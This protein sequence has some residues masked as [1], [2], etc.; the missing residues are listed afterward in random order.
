MVQKGDSEKPPPNYIAARERAAG[1]HKFVF[2][3]HAHKIS[4]GCFSEFR[5]H[6]VAARFAYILAAETEIQERADCA[7]P[8]SGNCESRET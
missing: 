1:G 4:R 2:Q 5:F 6:F 3:A 8:A 7:W